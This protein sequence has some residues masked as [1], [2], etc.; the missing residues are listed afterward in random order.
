M[1]TLLIDLLDN[2]IPE[3]GKSFTVQ[4]YNPSGGGK[5]TC[6]SY[7]ESSENMRNPRYKFKR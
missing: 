6:I 2:D 1:T 3:L 5:L 4:L 7:R